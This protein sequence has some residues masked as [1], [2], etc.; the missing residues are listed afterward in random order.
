MNIPAPL[1]IRGREIRQDEQG[2]ICLNDIHKSGGFSTNQKPDDWGRLPTTTKLIAIVLERKAGKS[3]FFDKTQILSVYCAKR[4]RDCGVWADPVLALAYAKYLS[5]D[6]HYEV[7]E[8]FLRYKAA[9]PSLADDVL[10]RATP[11]ANEWAGVR[12]MTRSTR[13]QFTGTLKDHGVAGPGY[14]NCT[15]AIYSTVFGAPASKLK[16]TRGLP[17]K[18]NLRDHM[19][20]DELIYTMAGESLAKERIIDLDCQGNAQCE[21]ASAKSASFIRSALEADRADRKKPR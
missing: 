10:S 19:T 5:A 4:G 9:D 20:T 15:N 1:K 21:T 2:R 11:E 3:R 17:A 16:E 8:V 14:A 13:N 7:N 18:S 12:A 6:L